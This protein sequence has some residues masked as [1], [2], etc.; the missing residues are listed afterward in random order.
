MARSR[1]GVVSRDRSDAVSPAVPRSCSIRSSNIAADPAIVCATSSVDTERLSPA[2][3]AASIN[4]STI[5]KKYAGP[6]P[7][8]AVTA[9]SCS[10]ETVSTAPTESNS[11]ATSLSCSLVANL[12]LA[13][14]L[15]PAPTSA[16]AFGIT[17]TTGVPAVSLDSRKAGV[18]PAATGIN[19]CSGTASLDSAASWEISA[20]T[21]GPSEGLTAMMTNVAFSTASRTDVTSTEYVSARYRARSGIRSATTRSL[22]WRPARSKPDSRA[23]PMLPPPTIAILAMPLSMAD[24]DGFRDKQAARRLLRRRHHGQ[25][26]GLHPDAALAVDDGVVLV[27][28]VLPDLHAGADHPQPAVRRQCA[29]VGGE[30]DGRRPAGAVQAKRH[31]RRHI[32]THQREQHVRRQATRPHP[33]LDDRWPAVSGPQRREQRPHI[34]A[35]GQVHQPGQRV[36]GTD[37]SDTVRRL[38]GHQAHRRIGRQQRWRQVF[39]LAECHHG[40]HGCAITLHELDVHHADPAPA[41][42][43]RGHQP[44]RTGVGRPQEAARD[45]HRFDR[46]MA[47]L[48]VFSSGRCTARIVA[49]RMSR[50]RGVGAQREHRPAVDLGPDSPVL[51]QLACVDA[52][53]DLAQRHRSAE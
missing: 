48:P 26:A 47:Q 34:T 22:T 16:G 29:Q 4:A 28:P 50:T 40:V 41:L 23:S 15:I 42:T 37:R 51:V 32:S 5:R 21:D 1:A 19:T 24:R 46:A 35:V 52:G 14:A 43:A 11:A 9:S 27:E 18:T 31:R 3:T 2:P 20:T 10:S 33:H 6:E 13:M 39:G 17:R 12:P 45:R 49:A 38:R 36:A 8:T 25:L 53:V 7:D 44:H 30:L